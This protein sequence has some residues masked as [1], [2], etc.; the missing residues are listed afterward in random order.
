M[1]LG[2][3]VLTFSPAPALS[4]VERD[5]LALVRQLP[6]PASALDNLRQEASRQK[7]DTVVAMHSETLCR[8]GR[9]VMTARDY[10]ISNA[11]RDFDAGE[12]STTADIVRTAEEMFCAALGAERLEPEKAE[13]AGT[14]IRLAML[15]AIGTKYRVII[16]QLPDWISTEE[17]LAASVDMP[18]KPS[19]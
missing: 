18:S 12:F 8:D 3:R 10:R 16:S 1:S 2:L 4:A 17:W 13:G 11:V 14:Y 19:A 5:I 15:R 6:N 7:K 9:W